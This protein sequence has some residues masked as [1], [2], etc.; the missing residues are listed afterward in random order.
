MGKRHVNRNMQQELSKV[1]EIRTVGQPLEACPVLLDEKGVA[2]F[3]RTS[4][5]HVASMR[6]V[7]VSDNELESIRTRYAHASNEIDDP[8]YTQHIPV[9]TLLFKQHETAFDQSGRAAVLISKYRQSQPE[10]KIFNKYVVERDS[11]G[12]VSQAYRMVRVIRRIS[13]TALND[14]EIL[15]ETLI[16]R[17][18][19]TFYEP[20]QAEHIESLKTQMHSIMARS[21]M[22]ASRKSG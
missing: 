1:D 4:H 12:S 19:S 10:Y 13:E 6:S 22:L 5:E 8:E 17:T 16:Q 20:L 11:D 2:P 7:Y 15:E 14:K 9:L 3:Y 21:A 18:Q